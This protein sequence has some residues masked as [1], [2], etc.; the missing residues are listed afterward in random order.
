MVHVFVKIAIFLCHR[1]QPTTAD[2]PWNIPNVSMVRWIFKLDR[3]IRYN[4]H[5]GKSVPR[6]E[7]VKHNCGPDRYAS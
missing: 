1:P 4:V 2:R 5:E 6:D 3:K 7:D